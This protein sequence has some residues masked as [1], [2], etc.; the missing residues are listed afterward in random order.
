MDKLKVLTI[1]LLSTALVRPIFAEE[2]H[3]I[4]VIEI[5]AQKRIQSIQTV[6]IAV[7]SIDKGTLDKYNIAQVDQLSMVSP[8]LHATRS[9]GGRSNYF[10]RGIGMDD[11]NLSS[12]P[13]IGLYL[14]DVAVHNPMLANFALFD[15]ERV[16]ILRG[17]Q[18]TL[19]G[20]N[21][22][23]GAINFISTKAKLNG[24]LEGRT[25]L[26]LGSFNQR[27]IDFATS[28][29][30]SDTAAIRLSGFS[31]T[32]DGQVTSTVEGNDSEYNNINRYG[33]RGQFYS[34][35]SDNVSLTASVYGGKQDQIAEVKTFMQAGDGETRIKLDDI[36]LSKNDSALIKPPND[37]DSIGGYVKLEWSAEF[38]KLVSISAFENVESRRA[39]D[40]SSQSAP[41]NV[42]TLV[43]YNTSDTEYWSQEL[44]LVSTSSG[45]VNWI[46]GL[47]YNEEQGDIVQ[48]AFIDPVGPGRP[49]DAIDDAGVG[50]LFDRGAWVELNNKTWSV[51]GQLDYS[52]TEKVSLSA[53][54]R[55]TEQQL[56]PV[57]NSVGMMMDLPEKPFPLGT[58]G[59]YSLGNPGFN[60]L[61]DYAGFEVVNNFINA[62][63][64][65]PA[66]A[67]IDETFD[68]WGGKLALSYQSNQDLLFYVS[69]ARGF[70][71]GA[72]NSNPTTTAYAALMDRVVKPEILVTTEI[73]WKADL[74]DDSLR[75]NGALFKNSWDNYQ[76][77]QVYNPGNPADLFATLINMPKAEANGAEIDVNWL[78]THTTRFNFSATWLDAKVVDGSL[79][80]TGI[81]VA[82]QENFQNTVVTGN[83]LTNSPEWRINASIQQTFF[84]GDAELD[85]TLFYNYID[86]H[87]HQL[88]GTS[89]ADWQ[90]NFS[91][92][93]V[94]LFGFNANW[95]FGEQQQ[96]QLSFW[97]QN[98]TDQ[99]YCSERATIPGLHA[100]T[101]KLCVQGQPK[102]LGAAIKVLF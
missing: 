13:A 95:L 70:K 87:I 67:K 83:K 10:I 66:S 44:Q 77:Y 15:I 16:E 96:Y 52:I 30:V 19:F 11:F 46:A 60:P 75:V 64:G 36:D 54:Y 79:D 99:A 89:S 27:N 62:N 20:K 7:T 21:T 38:A 68:E 59:W 73:G 71:M 90:Y 86:E 78:A 35:I 2:A 9:I 88:A 6:P 45:S 92:Q 8:S 25:K 41:S 1:S 76:F 81:P 65:V 43:T 24:D 32:R 12:V 93:A 57:V 51:Y 50:P 48:T 91:E 97:G 23:G 85:L 61:T 98:I 82:Q 69:I 49:D 29:A 74:F 56:S 28:L 84:I 14:D 53:G 4:E 33:L 26:T 40:W 37:I 42:V 18:N 47:L 72:V 31:H 39:D 3:K 100:D 94:S 55:W 5:T 34:Q 101:A 80:V 102:T 63:G 58:F 22:T 17:P